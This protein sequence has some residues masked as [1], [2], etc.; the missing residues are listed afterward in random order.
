MGK[1][2]RK[3]S[4]GSNNNGGIRSSEIGHMVDR[5]LLKSLPPV[6]PFTSALMGSKSKHTMNWRTT[7]PLHVPKR[8]PSHTALSAVAPSSPVLIKTTQRPGRVICIQPMLTGRPP[9]SLL[10]GSATLRPILRKGC[11]GEAQPNTRQVCR[12]PFTAP[13]PPLAPF[14]FEV[15][16]SRVPTFRCLLNRHPIG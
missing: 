16:I 4:T 8:A 13:P 9:L 1:A 6:A 2:Q 11:P 5:S 7:H 12:C 15:S 3:S 14:V 10:F